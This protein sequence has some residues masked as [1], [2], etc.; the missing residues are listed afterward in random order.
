MTTTTIN[1]RST[2]L[3]TD[4]VRTVDTMRS[5]AKKLSELNKIEERMRPN[6]LAA[7]GDR[8]EKEIKHQIRILEPSVTDSIGQRDTEVTV[9]ALKR[10]GLPV[11]TRSPEFVAPASFSALVKKGVVPE[12]LIRRTS[13]SIVIVH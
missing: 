10:L 6:V 13:E 12:E 3:I 9:E 5:L 2:K 8:A 7:I 11:N 1:L 4:Y